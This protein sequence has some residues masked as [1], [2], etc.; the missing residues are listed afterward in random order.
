[1]FYTDN[2]IR[3]AERYADEQERWLK[4]LPICCKCKERIQ[5]DSCYVINDEVYHEK[6]ADKLF[7][8]WTE[9]LME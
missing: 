4:K 3:D 9:D 5:D 1:M 7:R 2:P 8:K 6:C